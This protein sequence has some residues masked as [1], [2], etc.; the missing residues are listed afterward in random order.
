MKV[1][2]PSTTAPNYD[3]RK[4]MEIDNVFNESAEIGTAKIKCA[5]PSVLLIFFHIFSEMRW[6]GLTM[7]HKEYKLPPIQ[8]DI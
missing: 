6:Y 5:A 8:S 3:A 2:C 4:H 7:A 1:W